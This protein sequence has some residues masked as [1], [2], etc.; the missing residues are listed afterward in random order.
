MDTKENS[1][2]LIAFH[3]FAGMGP[4][5]ISIVNSF[6]VEDNV[7][8]FL[9][10]KD[11]HYYTRN[12]KEKLRTKATIIQT[13]SSSMFITLISVINGFKCKYARQI[14]KLCID[15]N[16]HLIHD[17]TGCIDYQFVRKMSRKFNWMYTVHDLYPHE[18][19]KSFFKELRQKK[20]Y[21]GI[22]KAI[23]KSNQLITNSRFQ[24]EDLI[25]T[26][27]TKPI[28]LIPFPSLITYSIKQGNESIPELKD[29]GRYILFFGRIEEYKGLT[30]LLQAYSNVDTDIKLV[31]AGSGEFHYPIDDSRVIFLNR[32]IDDFEV[33][34]LFTNSLCVIYPYISATQSGVLAVASYF[35]TPIIASDVPFFLEILG[36]NYI[37]LFKNGDVKD[38]SEKIDNFIH[39]ST[40]QI[41]SIKNK[42]IVLYQTHYELQTLRQQLL[43]IYQNIINSKEKT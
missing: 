7:R 13:K 16:I 9:I 18:A 40:E 35:K 15:E 38:L 42:M 20:M 28:Y 17:L 32:Y 41:N 36:S 26:Y 12:I 39:F 23:S 19:K 31:I 37:G 43:T 5:V 33:K 1:V 4:Y 11:D 3:S 14:E 27:T 10:E 6:H 8:F 25:K 30:I 22:F 24:Y 34:S 29:V 2:L 21:D